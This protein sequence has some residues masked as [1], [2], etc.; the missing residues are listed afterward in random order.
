VRPPGVVA[1]HVPARHESAVLQHRSGP[2]PVGSTSYRPTST[3]EARSFQQGC[4]RCAAATPQRAR[5]P[6][7]LREP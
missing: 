7:S 2:V 5:S 3:C 6:R 1:L 4:Q